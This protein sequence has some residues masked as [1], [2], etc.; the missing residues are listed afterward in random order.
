MYILRIRSAKNP[1]A[2]W[3]LIFSG[4]CP[5]R[6]HVFQIWWRSV[7][8]FSVGRWSNFAISYWLWQSSIQHSHTTVWACCMDY[9]L[10]NSIARHP[11]TLLGPSISAILSVQ[12]ELGY[13]R[14]V[15]DFVTMAIGNQSQWRVPANLVQVFLV[16]VSCTQLNTAVSQHRN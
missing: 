5:R 11:N 13:S 9:G 7:Q 1:W 10:L 8:G 4:K 14:F 2:D 12:A 15:L 16:Q 6:N 3:P